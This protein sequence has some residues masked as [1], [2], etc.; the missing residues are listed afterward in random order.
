MDAAKSQLVTPFFIPSAQANDDRTAVLVRFRQEHPPALGNQEPA[1][2][3]GRKRFSGLKR[4]VFPAVLALA[5][6]VENRG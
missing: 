2:V 1:A 5:T 6:V 3:V 4:F